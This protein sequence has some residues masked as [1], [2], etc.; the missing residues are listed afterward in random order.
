MINICATLGG[1]A[2]QGDYDV[3]MGRPK[4]I[5]PTRS[6]VFAAADLVDLATF[7]AALLAAML[8]TRDDFNKVFCFPLMRVVDDNTAEATTQS[9][10]DGYEEVLNESVPKYTLQ[11]TAGTCQAQAMV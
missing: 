9:L 10:A 4:Y 3:R 11:S 1:N 6:K 7:K 5:L 8:L 2:G